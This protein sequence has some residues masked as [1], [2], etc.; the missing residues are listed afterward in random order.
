MVGWW[1]IHLSWVGHPW[2]RVHHRNPSS[3]WPYVH[4]LGQPFSVSLCTADKNGSCCVSAAILV[5]WLLVKAELICINSEV[6]LDVCVS[7]CEG[8]WLRASARS[9][10]LPGLYIM[11]MSYCCS[12]ISILCSLAGAAMRF[13]ILIIS[14]SL[15]S[16]LTVNVLLYR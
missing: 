9:I 3:F 1:L 13:F 10:Y 6:E 5:G 12:Q 16:V 11:I 14:S 4:L 7:V 8:R 15:W 2:L